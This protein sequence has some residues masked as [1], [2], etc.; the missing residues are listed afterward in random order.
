MPQPPAGS[1]NIGYAPATISTNRDGTTAQRPESPGSSTDR[2][3]ANAMAPGYAK[4]YSPSPSSWPSSGS[5][6][7]YPAAAGQGHTTPRG[8][9]LSYLPSTGLNNTYG[10]PDNTT[11]VQG[12]ATIPNPLPSRQSLVDSGS[13][14]HTPTTSQEYTKPCSSS[15]LDQDC[16]TLRS[17]SPSCQPSAGFD[18]ADQGSATTNGREY[19]M[20]SGHLSSDQ[21]YSTPCSPSPSCQSSAS[22]GGANHAP[23][24]AATGRHYAAPCDPLASCQFSASTDNTD[25]AHPAAAGGNHTTPLSPSP[26]CSRISVTGPAC[27]PSDSLGNVNHAPTTA[28]TA[29]GQDDTTPFLYHRVNPRRAWTALIMLPLLLRAGLI[30]RLAVIYRPTRT[31]K[32]VLILHLRAGSQQGRTIRTMLFLPPRARTIPGLA[33]VQRRVGPRQA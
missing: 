22:L 4:P 17:P 19:S 1:V 11:R 30:P 10:A 31:M 2:A 18:G 14:G 12:C 29:T 32:R 27:W 9:F 16:A 26:S 28:T 6:Y 15:S 20:V 33:T 25:N 21:D 8:H 23:A 3:F 7:V 24:T 13:I 5:D